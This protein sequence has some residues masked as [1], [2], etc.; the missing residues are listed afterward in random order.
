MIYT[1]EIEYMF[2]RPGELVDY[3]IINSHVG[4]LTICLVFVYIK[5]NQGKSVKVNKRQLPAKYKELSNKV[6]HLK[7][8]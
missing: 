5:H 7:L 4:D 8:E 6:N 1:A 2:S 3:N